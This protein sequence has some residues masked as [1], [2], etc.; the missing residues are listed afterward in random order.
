MTELCRFLWL[1]LVA[2]R[3]AKPSGTHYAAMT[4]HGVPQICIF[5][6]VGREAWRISQRA[7]E[8]RVA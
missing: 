7:V 4:R 3:A 2:Y 1:A 8:E 6:G 5:V